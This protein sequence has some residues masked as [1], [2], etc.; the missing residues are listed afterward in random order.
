MLSA[1]RERFAIGPAEEAPYL[2]RYVAD[3]ATGPA[4]P[5][6]D[7]LDRLVRQVFAIEDRLVRERDI[8]AAG[9]RIS[10]TL[11]G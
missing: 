11:P 1:I 5:A 7:V 4:P 9:I 6:R 2:Y 10:G 8:A 3:R